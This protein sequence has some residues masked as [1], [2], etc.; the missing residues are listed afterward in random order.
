MQKN[1]G[2]QRVEEWT[3]LPKVEA[4]EEMP[5]AAQTSE[6]FEPFLKKWQTMDSEHV[7]HSYV[8]LDNC[9][10]SPEPS[11]LSL[12]ATRS[13]LNRLLKVSVKTRGGCGSMMLK[14][15]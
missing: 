10:L 2:K 1:R 15:N 7:F 3:D 8:I 12:I 14:V 9:L 11:A 4:A 6:F 13:S 5:S